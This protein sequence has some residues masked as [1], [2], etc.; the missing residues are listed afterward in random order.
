MLNTN[1]KAEGNKQKCKM[2]SKYSKWNISATIGSSSYSKL[3]LMGP[4]LT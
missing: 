2:A 1:T 3:E 4:N